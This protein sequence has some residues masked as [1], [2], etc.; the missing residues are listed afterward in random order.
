MLAGGIWKGDML[1]ADIEKF[2]KHGRARNPSS[3]TQCKRSVN[4][5]KGDKIVFSQSHMMQ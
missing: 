3:K 4:A 2:G 1:V 5:K